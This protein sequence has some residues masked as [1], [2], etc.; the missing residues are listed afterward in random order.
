M[1]K[2]KVWINPVPNH[3]IMVGFPAP[4][5]IPNH[6]TVIPPPVYVPTPYSGEGISEMPPPP[7]GYAPPPGGFPSAGP[8]SPQG[9]ETSN[10]MG[11]GGQIN[12]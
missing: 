10:P 6:V 4:T 7:G 5:A 3:P 2:K 11:P 8:M 9:G 12:L 1:Y